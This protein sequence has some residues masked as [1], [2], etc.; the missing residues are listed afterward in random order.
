M[1]MTSLYDDLL[2]NLTSPVPKLVKSRNYLEILTSDKR[3]LFCLK[4]LAPNYV[5]Y[6]LSVSLHYLSLLAVFLLFRQLEHIVL[7]HYRE[8]KEVIVA[9]WLYIEPHIYCFGFL[10]FF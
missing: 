4:T 8:V 5:K 7:V 2:G 10:H 1:T 3:S 9:V 6:E